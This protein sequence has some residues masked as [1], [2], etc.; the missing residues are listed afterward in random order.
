MADCLLFKSKLDR[1]K[2][3]KAICAMDEL[4]WSE[5]EEDFNYEDPMIFSWL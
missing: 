1:F 2:G 4:E 5:P 3:K